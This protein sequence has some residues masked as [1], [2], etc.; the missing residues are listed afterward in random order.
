MRSTALAWNT[1]AGFT[2]PVVF[3]RCP[4]CQERNLVK[5]DYFACVI[6]G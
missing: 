3:R 6:C 2:Q 4:R 1:P 5:D